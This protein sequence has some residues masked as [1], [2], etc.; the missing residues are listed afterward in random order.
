MAD[1]HAQAVETGA[2]AI[3][4]GV[5]RVDGEGREQPRTPMAAPAGF[6]DPG[7]GSAG[8]G[9]G[10]GTGGAAPGTTYPDYMPAEA[11]L[12]QLMAS[13]LMFGSWLRYSFL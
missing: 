2:A 8:Q 7:V 11:D 12:A 6:G 13:W 10:R 3:E 4:V 1:V 9:G 5:G